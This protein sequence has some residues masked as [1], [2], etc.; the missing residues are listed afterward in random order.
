MGKEQAKERSRRKVILNFIN[1]DFS[2]RD[3]SRGFTAE[4]F[5]KTPALNAQYK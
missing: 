4:L 2:S 3:V 1:I 5:W